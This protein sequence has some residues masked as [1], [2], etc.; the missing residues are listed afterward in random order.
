MIKA[1]YWVALAFNMDSL[2]LPTAQAAL[3]IQPRTTTGIMYTGRV[4]D[5]TTKQN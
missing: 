5:V 1:S 3:G 4:T 2:A